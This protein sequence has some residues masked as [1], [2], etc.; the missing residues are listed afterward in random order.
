[1]VVVQISE[2]AIARVHM[3]CIEEQHKH[4]GVERKSPEMQNL[5]RGMRAL[6]E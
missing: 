5:R 2:L 3:C 1:M 6:S 4:R